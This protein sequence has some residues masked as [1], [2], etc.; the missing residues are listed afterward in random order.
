M[1]DEACREWFIFF[2]SNA[3]IVKTLDAQHCRHHSL[4]LFLCE[5][6]ELAVFGL[7][8][9]KEKNFDQV[10]HLQSILELAL[11]VKHGECS[12]LVHDAF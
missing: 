1:L 3:W 11:L 2:G 4:S 9:L 8:F 10:G 12:E 5:L 6:F 7:Q